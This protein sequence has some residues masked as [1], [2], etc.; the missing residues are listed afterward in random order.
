M[1]E[2]T[3]PSSSDRASAGSAPCRSGGSAR[4][5]AS[6]SSRPG[7]RSRAPGCV[8][9]ID[10]MW[11]WS[12]IS[13][14]SA[15]ST[16][17]DA[18]GLLGVVDEQRRG[19]AAGS[20]RSERVTRPTGRPRAVDG[21]RGA[22]VDV[23]DLLGDVGDEVV[24]ADRQRLGVHERA[25]GHRQRDHAARDVAVPAAR[26]PPP[27]RAPARAPAR[28]RSA[29]SRCSSRAARRR[30]RSRAAARRRGCRRP[31]TSPSP[32]LVGQRGDVHRQHPDA[33][34]TSRSRRRT[35][36]SPL[37]H[38][39]DRAD[40][41]RRVGRLRGLARLADVP[42]GERALGHDARRARRRRRRPARG[43]APR[44]PSSGRPRGR[45]ALV[46]ERERAPA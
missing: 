43:R 23:L 31:T 34:G 10:P 8:V 38:V 44:A 28:R 21:D 2:R 5:R 42:A 45:V 4:R 20:T 27:C 26:R 1:S 3:A 29:A 16:P 6:R 37:E 17:G 14:I 12:R 24:E 32:M 19:A 35:T 18:L 46:G 30:A 40:R 41:R 33:A 9:S 7:R 11:W 15:C 36:S 22:V 25:A 13:T 39:D